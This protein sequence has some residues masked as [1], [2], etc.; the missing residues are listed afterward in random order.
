MK[1]SLSAEE[2]VA[3]LVLAF[4]AGVLTSAQALRGGGS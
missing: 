3:I 2:L 4:L 1:L